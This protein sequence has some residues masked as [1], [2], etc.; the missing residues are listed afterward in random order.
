MKVARPRMAAVEGG[1]AQS[2]PSAEAVRDQ[3]EMLLSSDGFNKSP[4][5]SGFL[6]FVV[7]ETLVGNASLLKENAI[8]VEV[9]DRDESFDPKTN[10]VV[11]VEASRLRHRLREYF[12][13]PAQTIR[14]I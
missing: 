11:R 10:A 6:R 13:G 12:L 9:F 1:E 14:S 3:L 5:M 7:S 4:R 2:G 8:A